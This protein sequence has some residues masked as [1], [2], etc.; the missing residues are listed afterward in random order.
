VN[1]P[2]GQTPAGPDG[3][4]AQRREQLELLV[5]LFLIVPTLLLSFVHGAQGQVGFPLVA[6]S[7]IARDVALVSL[8]V[9]FL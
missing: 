9:F 1:H 6:V 4:N 5:F 8:V 2:C 7:V 3:P